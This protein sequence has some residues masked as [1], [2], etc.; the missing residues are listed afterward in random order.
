MAGGM[1]EVDLST[2]KVRLVVTLNRR[3]SNMLILGRLIQ[4]DFKHNRF[5]RLPYIVIYPVLK[6]KHVGSGK[7]FLK[8]VVTEPCLMLPPFVTFL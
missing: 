1:E 7:Q 4:E 5:N 2:L 8:C 3:F 6:F